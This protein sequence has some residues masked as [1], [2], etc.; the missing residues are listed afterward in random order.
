VL[1][2]K[3]QNAHVINFNSQSP[4]AHIRYHYQRVNA[5]YGGSLLDDLKLPISPQ[6]IHK[7]MFKWT[8]LL[9]F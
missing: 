1:L 4:N 8:W 2:A 5:S 9:L 7:K 6:E 3:R